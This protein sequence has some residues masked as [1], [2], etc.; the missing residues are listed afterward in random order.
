MR[1]PAIPSGD[2][3]ALK[4]YSPEGHILGRRRTL[5]ILPAK[6]DVLG[7][8]VSCPSGLSISQNGLHASDGRTTY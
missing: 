3:R 1:P 6:R 4:D 2:L 7:K 8:T 5:D